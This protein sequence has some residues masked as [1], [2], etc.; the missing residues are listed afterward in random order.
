MSIFVSLVSRPSRV[1]NV[2][3]GL[4]MRLH[5]HR[6]LLSLTNVHSED[7]MG[8]AGPEVHLCGSCDSRRV[9]SLQPA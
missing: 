8:T 7:S 5:V 4:G 3:N 1:F 6:Q 2:E 9:A